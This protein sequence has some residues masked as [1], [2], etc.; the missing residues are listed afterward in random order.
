[1][2]SDETQ[3]AAL[4]ISGDLFFSSKITGTAEQLGLR[5]DVEGNAE[6]ACQRAAASHYRCLLLDLAMP[7]LAVANVMASL[8]G[9]NRPRVIAFGSHVNTVRLEEARAAGCDEVMA[10]SR[11][12]QTLPELLKQCLG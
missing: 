3:K 12:S 5:V 8:P 6:Q 2:S 11:F 1:M 10:R 4:L 7:N 9:E